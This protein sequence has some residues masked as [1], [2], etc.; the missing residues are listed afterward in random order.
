V[1][2]RIEKSTKGG[3]KT[4]KETNNEVRTKRGREK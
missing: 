4:R 3:Q 2:R 1:R